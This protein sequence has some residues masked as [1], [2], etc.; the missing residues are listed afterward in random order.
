MRRRGASLSMGVTRAAMG[1]T[2]RSRRPTSTASGTRAKSHAATSSSC[3]V[4]SRLKHGANA[5]QRGRMPAAA[6]HLKKNRGALRRSR[7]GFDSLFAPEARRYG[8]LRYW[9]RYD[10]SLSILSNAA[11]G[12]SFGDQ[13]ACN[14]CPQQLHTVGSPAHCVQRWD[15]TTH[16]VSLSHLQ[17]FTSLLIQHAPLRAAVCMTRSYTK[18]HAP[19]PAKPRL[20]GTLH[21]IIATSRHAMAPKL[22]FLPSASV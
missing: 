16:H 13:P 9:Y 4:A 7:I 5:A 17:L 3:A 11:W 10:R 22:C 1:A 12:G 6:L 8:W 20:R 19:N 15:G 18:A 2:S 14:S 21:A